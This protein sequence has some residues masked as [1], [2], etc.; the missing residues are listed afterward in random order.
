M[1]S[2]K[3]GLVGLSSKLSKI[4]VGDLH[5]GLWQAAVATT[6]ELLQIFSFPEFFNS[7]ASSLAKLLDADGAALIVY[8]GPDH[9]KY[10]L[11]YGLQSVNQ[12]EVS[13]FRFPAGKGTVGRALAHRPASVYAR[14]CA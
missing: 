10:K 5:G 13:K 8:D 9:L 1:V 4:P 7:T 6:A 12:E 11:F 3:R 14:L 2:S